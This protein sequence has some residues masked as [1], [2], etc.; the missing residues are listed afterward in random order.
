MLPRDAMDIEGLSEKTV[1]K[2]IEELD[3]NKITDIYELKEES[4]LKLEGFKE[5]EPEIS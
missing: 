2:L 5:K 1:E 4:L 3:V